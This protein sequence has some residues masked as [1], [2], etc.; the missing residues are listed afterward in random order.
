MEVAAARRTER[1]VQVHQSNA[2]AKSKSQ[3]RV[4]F[5]EKPTYAS[6]LVSA[7]V[8]SDNPKHAMTN[9]ENGLA[10]L[11]VN[12]ES[13]SPLTHLKT[14]AETRASSETI[15]IWIVE[16]PQKSAHHVLTYVFQVS[17]YGM[18]AD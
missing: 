6:V 7:I 17:C 16:L 5:A 15:Q 3:S 11:D 1:V 18:H 12:D 4:R 9:L 10:S 14:K 8:V 2:N 13:K